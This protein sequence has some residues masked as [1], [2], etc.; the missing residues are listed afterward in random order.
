M[1]HL[2]ANG[3]GESRLTS[4]TSGASSGFSPPVEASGPVPR[5]SWRTR[6]RGFSSLFLAINLQS[7]SRTG[8]CQSWHPDFAGCNMDKLQ[9]SATRPFDDHEHSP[10]NMGG[11]ERSA[12]AKHL[13]H[14]ARL[15]DRP[16]VPRCAGNSGVYKEGEAIRSRQSHHDAHH[17][18]DSL[19]HQHNQTTTDSFV[20]QLPSAT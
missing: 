6:A 20:S 16:G 1:P 2:S 17:P 19:D 12:I 8:S 14:H 4:S 11:E 3:P 7:G 13:D 9:N 15:G 18:L 5:L 10:E